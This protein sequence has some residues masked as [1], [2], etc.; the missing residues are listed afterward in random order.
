M[1]GTEEGEPV[2]IRDVGGEDGS[3]DGSDLDTGLVVASV[4]NIRLD[5]SDEVGEVERADAAR[6]GVQE[7]G[8]STGGVGGDLVG[9]L[10]PVGDDDVESAVLQAIGDSNNSLA[11]DWARAK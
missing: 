8:D 11:V 4:V 6:E 2:D 3:D 9:D 7:V 10:G 1:D 5:L